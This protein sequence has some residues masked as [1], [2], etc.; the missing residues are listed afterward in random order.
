MRA[1]Q[2]LL[3]IL[4]NLIYSLKPNIFS[5]IFVSS[6]QRLAKVASSPAP[7]STAVDSKN[8]PSKS[9]I[10]LSKAGYARCLF[11]VVIALFICCSCERNT[12]QVQ[13]HVIRLN[14]KEEPAT[15]D[16]RKGGDVISS[17]MHFLLFEGLVKLEHDG[18]I[19]PAQAQS[20]EISPDGT[21]YTFHLRETTWSNGTPVTAHDFKQSWLDILDPSFPSLNAHLLY[22]IKNAERAKKRMGS[23]E[24]V[25]IEAL[26]AKT[27]VV[28]LEH[29][30]PY[31]LELV[32][33]C[34]FFP[35]SKLKDHEQPDW[36]YHAG[37]HFTSNGPFVLKE[38][39]HNNEIVAVRNPLYW[40]QQRVLPDRVHFTMIDN[41]TTALELF[42]NG[43]IDMIGEPLCSL[44]TDALHSL[45]SKDKLVKHPVGGTTIIAFNTTQVPFNHPKIR[46][47]FSYAIH[48]HEIVSHITQLNQQV[49]TCAVPPILKKNQ[50]T[51]LFKDHDV[52]TARQLLREGME[53]LG[54][55]V[56]AFKKVSLV[57]MSSD[58]HHKIAQAIQRQWAEDL[59]IMIAL[60]NVDNKVLINKLTKRDFS[61]AQ[62]M[63][64]A[65]Y[66][67]QMNILE[68]FKFKDNA[69][70]YS[71]WENQQYIDLLNQSFYQV[72]DERLSTLQ[73][74]EEIFLNEM[75]VAPIYHWDVAFMVNPHL[76]GVKLTP[77]GD[78]VF[79]DLNLIP[80][81]LLFHD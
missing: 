30:T 36:A 18:A 23:L 35:V 38:W 41:E 2:H 27:L 72:G 51:S 40:D 75:P 49:A 78:I 57:Y 34:V 66:N 9:L 59:G 70:N 54:I 80:Q 16:P 28:T 56:T 45:K 15:L 19:S 13:D 60:E 17:H 25:G 21:V 24:E 68:R 12:K 14:M 47:A 39:K 58:L 29:P 64:V 74:A 48:R 62:T 79:E 55:D 1:K 37:P 61:L 43:K 33:F 46:K 69:K 20:Y 52:A 44:P 53:E 63:W 22:P 4:R 65:Q 67:D 3:D 31:F 5:P 77:I 11:F 42:H 8:L 10:F 26:D 50:S 7:E 76:K 81:R 71:Q 6:S 73:Q 32:S